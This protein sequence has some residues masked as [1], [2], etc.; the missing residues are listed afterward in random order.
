MQSFDLARFCEIVQKYKI[1]YTYVAPPVVVHLAKNPIIDNYDL[2][3]LKT[4]T[5]GAAPLTK[6]LIE[7]V[8]K[9][10]NVGTK[11]AYGLSET[12]PLVF[13]QVS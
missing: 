4:I 3:T 6:E 8:H 7:A 11:Q 12:S 1:T 5:S 2:S 13:I 10:L 9:R